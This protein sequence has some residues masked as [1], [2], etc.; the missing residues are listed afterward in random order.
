MRKLACIL[1]MSWCMLCFLMSSFPRALLLLAVG[2]HRWASAW[3]V[4]LFIPH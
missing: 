3:L 1:R 4:Q 2:E